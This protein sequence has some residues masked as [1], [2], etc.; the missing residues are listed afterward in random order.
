MGLFVIIIN[1]LKNKK[2]SDLIVVLQPWFVFSFS[3][4][5]YLC[6]IILIY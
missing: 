3:I 6:L 1:T 5:I 4:I 2:I